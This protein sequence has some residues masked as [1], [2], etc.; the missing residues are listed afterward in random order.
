VAQQRDQE[1]RMRHRRQPRGPAHEANPERARRTQRA[2]RAFP[3]AL[4]P[5]RLRHVARL[6]GYRVRLSKR[7]EGRK[8]R[9][10]LC[11][12]PLLLR[13]S[14]AQRRLLSSRA[15]FRILSTLLNLIAKFALLKLA[16]L[17][18]VEFISQ[19][20]IVRPELRGDALE[21]R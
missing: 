15:L 3:A 19:L 9:G 1:P 20:V 12:P 7:L 8:L 17:M 5:S 4:R 2:D 14:C 6:D 18:C 21:L 13:Q 10:A 16:L 11:K